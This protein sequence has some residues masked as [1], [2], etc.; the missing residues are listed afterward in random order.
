MANGKLSGEGGSA[1]TRVKAYFL[2]VEARYLVLAFLCPYGGIC[3]KLA[4][5]S[6]RLRCKHWISRAEEEAKD[7]DGGSSSGTVGDLKSL[8]SR[9]VVL[10][11]LRHLSE[12]TSA[13]EL[14]LL[15]SL[16]KCD[17]V[18]RE[19]WQLC[20]RSAVDGNPA[21]L[22]V[23]GADVPSD[24]SAETGPNRNEAGQ[25]RSMLESPSEF[26][27]YNTQIPAL[28][29]RVDKASCWIMKIGIYSAYDERFLQRLGR[30][31]EA[32]STVN[33]KDAHLEKLEVPDQNAD[34][35][36]DSGATRQCSVL[37]HDLRAEWRVPRDLIMLV[38]A[39]NKIAAA[40]RRNRCRDVQDMCKGLIAAL[41][42]PSGES[43]AT[44]VRPA[45]VKHAGSWC[46]CA[47]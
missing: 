21:S 16:G 19:D 22:P 14:L 47:R 28:A 36:S 46:C 5:E 40:H 25:L 1:V 17:F 15:Q 24:T 11:V 32:M 12:L 45:D 33:E 3:D 27:R 30:Y 31:F 7:E 42:N 13:L 39:A 18:I 37:R 4:R 20:D 8:V 34:G 35:G 10:D 6:K 23:V 38:N 29:S 43:H 26:L 41:G 44:E 9:F 2:P